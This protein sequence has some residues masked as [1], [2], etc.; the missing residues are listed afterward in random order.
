MPIVPV[1]EL[2]GKTIGSS[3]PVRLLGH[4]KLSAVY[5]AHQPE[6]NRSVMFTLFLVPPSLPPDAQARFLERFKQEATALVQLNHPSILPVYDF[7]DYRS[8]PYLLTPFVNK[9]P[10]A[11][12]LKQRDHFS[13]QETLFILQQIASCID[14]A[15]SQQVIHGT[16][17]AS[18]ILIDNDLSIQ[19]AGFGFMRMLEARGILPLQQPYAHL[20]SIADTFLGSPEYLAPEYVQGQPPDGR[21]DVY[22]LG[23][24]LYELLSGTLPFKGANPYE[25]ALQHI[26]GRIP[27]LHEQFAFVPAALDVVI[28]QALE[29]NPAR[30]FQTAA[31]LVSVFERVL[32][33]LDATLSVS[34]NT[35]SPTQN[36]SPLPQSPTFDPKLTMPPT[37]NW[38]DEEM[39]KTSGLQA[40][41]HTKTGPML[42][43]NNASSASQALDFYNDA[44]PQIPGQPTDQTAAID[45]FVWWSAASQPAEEHGQLLSEGQLTSTKHPRTT[46]LQGTRTGK[47][48]G[49]PV[50][51]EGRRRTVAMLAGGGVVALGVLGFGGMSLAHLLT[52]KTGS[53]P[54]GNPQT[55][56]VS[57]PAQAKITTTSITPTP[58]ATPTHAPTST[59]TS[60]PTTTPVAAGQPVPTATSNRQPTPVPTTAPVPTPTPTAAPPAHTGTVIGATSQATNTG[61]SFTNPADGQSSLLIHLP[62][63][64]FTAFESACTHQGAATSYDAGAQVIRCTRHTNGT[65]DPATGTPTGGPPPQ[66]LQRVQIRVNGDG[67]ITTG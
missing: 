32:K 35:S 46:R 44:A 49:Q 42:A 43:I 17:S 40:I 62:N 52:K 39:L 56:L 67:T 41:S 9:M 5:E 22:A 26:Q 54:G 48:R 29:Q 61:Q 19:V 31:A 55:N 2:I 20:L 30:R 33:I 37:V 50:P 51:Q 64:N 3:R 8:Y 14:Y 23:I 27:S 6:Q 60:K 53:V 15:H 36:L 4:G 28:A 16:L 57:T 21:I 45:P 12:F 38:F 24:L 63:G 66:A 10:L 47:R 65:Y 7:G 11:R 1:E 34:K 59:P 13:P 18:N 25:I 58:Q